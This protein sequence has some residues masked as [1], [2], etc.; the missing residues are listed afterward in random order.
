MQFMALTRRKIDQFTDAQFAALLEPEAER[1]RELYAEGFGR[2]IWMRGDVP[3]SCWIIEADSEEDVREK[4]HTLPMH[5]K[6][7]LELLAVVPLKPYR[8]FCPKK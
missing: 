1:V 6:G 7:M 4:L 3:G 5:E 2:Q 8:G